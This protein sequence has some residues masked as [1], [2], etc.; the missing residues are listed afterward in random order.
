MFD[1][2]LCRIGLRLLDN[3]NR[4]PASTLYPS[5]MCPVCLGTR[6]PYGIIGMMSRVMGC[7]H[8]LSW[9]KWSTGQPVGSYPASVRVV[10]KLGLGALCHS[11]FCWS[12]L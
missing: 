10:H 7:I 2:T 11:T 5:P 9:A 1:P 4:V 8:I 3:Q 12:V 6:I